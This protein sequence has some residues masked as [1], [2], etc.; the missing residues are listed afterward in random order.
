MRRRDC[1]LLLGCAAAFYPFPVFGQRAR[2]RMGF[3]SINSP[4]N[5]ARLFAAFKEALHSL[6]HIE[7][8]T[9]DIDYRASSGDTTSLVELAQELIRL[10]PQVMLANSVTPTRTINRIAPDMPIVCPAFSDG[11]VPSLAT[12]FARP[13]GRVTG[14]ASDVESLIG[15]LAELV[16]DLIPDA[17]QIGY[18]SNPAG[19]SMGRFEQQIKTAAK[20]RGVEVRIAHAEKRDEIA[21]ALRQLADIKVRAV[22]VPTNGLFNSSRALIVETA[23]GLRLPLV[24]G[25]REGAMA[26]GLSS[27]GINAVENY[28]RAAAYV[29]KIL[30]G[31]APGD[32][33]IEFPTKIELV[34]NLKTAKALGLTVPSILLDRANEVI[35]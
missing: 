32:L 13:G 9:I 24:F 17:A 20:A 26:G 19:G 30:K 14:V 5:D 27:Y 7:G 33:P 10:K 8:R 21:G 6:G 34:I 1:I 25:T 12:S 11:F 35:E 18:L 15:K 29:D 23:M 3:L 2:P 4:Q 31:A 28:R 22:I 16:F